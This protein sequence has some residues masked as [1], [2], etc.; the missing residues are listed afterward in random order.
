[1]LVVCSLR[2][3]DEPVLLQDGFTMRFDLAFPPVTQISLADVHIPGSPVA[4]KLTKGTTR[5]C[6]K[7]P[8]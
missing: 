5:L 3:L 8:F 7:V 4:Y 1:M 6:N 2:L